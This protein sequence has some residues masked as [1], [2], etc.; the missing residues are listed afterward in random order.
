MKWNYN[1]K[2]Y[3][4]EYDFSWKYFGVGLLIFPV[5]NYNVFFGGAENTSSDKNLSSNIFV[6]EKGNIENSIEVV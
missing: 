1:I 4:Q 5:V 2:K 3:I 6:I